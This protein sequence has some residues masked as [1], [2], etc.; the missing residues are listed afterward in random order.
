[1]VRYSIEGGRSIDMLSMPQNRNEA[2][3]LAGE[4]LGSETLCCIRLYAL[5]Q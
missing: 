4:I 1:M 3:L 5:E 2:D